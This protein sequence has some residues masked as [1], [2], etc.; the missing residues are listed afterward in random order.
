[1]QKITRIV[2]ILLVT[3][4]AAANI[5]AQ[6]QAA[7]APNVAY[8]VNTQVT[9]NGRLYK[10]LQAHTSQVGWEPATTPALWQDIGA[11]GTSPTATRVPATRTNT[12]TGPTPV[13]PTRTNTPTGPTPVPP[14]R[15]PATNPPSG[16]TCA[17][18][19]NNATAYVGGNVVSYNGHNWT[20]KWWTQGWWYWCLDRQW[21]LRWWHRSN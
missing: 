8:A 15:V 2:I 12:P 4:F 9:Y 17:A 1:M 14:T 13:P 7:W 5:H 16:G 3:L 6:A 20:A 11:A 21:H 18:P 10:C 19:Y